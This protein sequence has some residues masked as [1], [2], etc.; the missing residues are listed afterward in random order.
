MA[1]DECLHDII[2]F[3]V[4]LDFSGISYFQGQDFISKPVPGTL[5]LILTGAQALMSPA[6]MRALH[7][8]TR[9]SPCHGTPS[10]N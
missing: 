5:C 4:Y 3:Q 6:L 8:I 9:G 1:Q 10:I 7:W 2:D